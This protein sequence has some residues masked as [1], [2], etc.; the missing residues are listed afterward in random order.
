VT[1]GTEQ[2]PAKPPLELSRSASQWE[3][4]LPL[5]SPDGPYDVRLTAAQGEEILTAK[6]FT[7][8]TAGITLLHAQVN[9]ATVSPG[10]YQLQIRRPNSEWSSYPIVVH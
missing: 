5:G 8:I 3:I 9:L 10:R 6:G 2:T 1:R 4:R 7:T